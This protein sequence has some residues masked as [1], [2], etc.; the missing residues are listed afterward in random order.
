MNSK[1]IYNTTITCPVCDQPFPATKVRLGSYRVASQDSDFAINYEGINPI[2]YDVLVCENCGYAAFQDRFANISPKEKKIIASNIAPHWNQKSYS[3]ERTLDSALDAFKLALYVLQL[4]KAKSSEIAKI[5][6]RIA[7]IYRWK[8][9]PRETE[10]L[11]FAL[12]YYSDAYQ[13]EDL[14][15][16][17][18]DG[19]HCT[20]LIAELHRKVGNIEEAT[21]WF[22]KLF[23]SPEARQ[24]QRLWNMAHDQYQLIK[25]LRQEE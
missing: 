9:D 25:D 17:K 4:R 11:K 21:Q 6:L 5:C 8:S 2:L 16:E 23:N 24:N 22:G 14:P 13:T 10:F 12:D 3:G 15:F 1:K 7:W 19:P 20:Y 18:L